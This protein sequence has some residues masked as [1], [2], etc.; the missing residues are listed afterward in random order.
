MMKHDAF[1]GHNLLVDAFGLVAIR[2]PSSCCILNI[3]IEFLITKFFVAAISSFKQQVESLQNLDQSVELLIRL[4][5]AVPGWSEK[6]VQV[7][8]VPLFN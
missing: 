1:C 7:Y 6:N 2:W 5:C 4:L 3:V 8:E